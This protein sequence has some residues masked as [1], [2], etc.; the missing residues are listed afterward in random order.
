[1]SEKYTPT[2]KD[3]TRFWKKVDKRGDD[4]CWFWTAC[5]H[6]SGHGE[7]KW[8]EHAR[9]AHRVSWQIHFGDIPEGLF[10]C[11]KCDEP[12]CVNPNH[13]YLGT[14]LDN[15]MDRVRRDHAGK[16]RRPI[17]KKIK[18]TPAERFWRKVNKGS[19]DE[20]WTWTAQK[21]K[22]GYGR[23]WWVNSKE[24]AHYVSWKIHYGEVP[25]G[26]HVIHTCN[27]PGCVNPLHLQLADR[28]T[29]G[30][31]HEKT[32]HL[33]WDKVDRRGINECWN[34]LAGKKYGGY[35]SFKW[36][37]HNIGAHRMSW[38]LHNGDIPDGM[39]VLH[40]CDNPACINPR[41]LRL[42]TH[43]ENLGDMSKKG[44]SAHG[45]RSGTAKL[46]ESQV[47]EIRRRYA[48][49]NILQKNL[50]SEYGIS[51]AQVNRI[52]HRSRWNK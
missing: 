29:Y 8:G 45:E 22:Q 15:M 52:V 18:I 25:N 43:A 40:E 19:D 20:C 1:M 24:N 49:G 4:E 48:S 7:I 33:F 3:L 36:K 41:H 14:P 42:G 27:R 34:W 26:L 51:R 38:I 37:G 6:R 32:L 46:T 5:T 10:V 30:V 13:L 31:S 17:R 28:P 21:D 12:S 11:H 9:R 39:E 44:R 2:D 47:R 35:G 23:I 50:A 16:Y